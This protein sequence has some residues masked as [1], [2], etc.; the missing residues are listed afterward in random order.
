MNSSLRALVYL[1][2][3]V[4][5]VGC[6]RHRGEVPLPEHGNVAKTVVE[7]TDSV[8]LLSD[9]ARIAR[10]AGA[11]ELQL[12]GLGVR[13]LGESVD[14]FVSLPK[15]RCAII[16]AR[17]SSTVDDL[18]LV[19]YA[20]DGTLYGSDEALDDLPT[21]IVCSKARDERLFVSARVAQGA[22][23]VAVGLNDVHPGARA[24]VLQAVGARGRK[25]KGATEA[26]AWPSLNEAVAS[27]LQALGGRWAD[28]RRVAL[29]L[30]ARIPTR[31][32]A[33]IPENRCL[34]ALALPET[35]N[36]E[37]AMQ[38]TDHTGRIIGLSSEQDGLLL[39][40]VCNPGAASHISFEFRPRNGQGLV[41]VALSLTRCKFSLRCAQR[42]YRITKKTTG[43]AKRGIAEQSAPVAGV[44]NLSPGI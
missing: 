38:A 31:L 37:I 34:S 22:G 7:P 29:P 19:A 26:E 35:A 16:Y 18:D 5:I 1:T 13:Q 43:A 17:A 23:L 42:C 14:G 30:D 20:D 15:N 3:A 44:S 11:A 32:S 28:L 10:K 21:L 25:G 8:A 6:G 40:V 24:A 12:I 4:L 39:M 41:L 27:S 33:Q 2:I 36:M 9:T